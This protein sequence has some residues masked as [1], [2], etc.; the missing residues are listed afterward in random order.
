MI[1]MRQ[2]ERRPDTL[3]EEGIKHQERIEQIHQ[4]IAKDLGCRLANNRKSINDKDAWKSEAPPLEE[5][6]GF[7]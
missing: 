1:K 3:V 5:G 7:T 4:S 2:W 6:T